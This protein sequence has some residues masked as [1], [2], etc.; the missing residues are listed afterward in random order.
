MAW[1]SSNELGTEGVKMRKR[2]LLFGDLHPFNIQFFAEGGDGEGNNG[3]SDNEGGAAAGEGGNESGNKDDQNKSFD[4]VLKDSNYQAE[5]D[6]RVQK[7]IKTAQEKWDLAMN[8]KLSEAE[9]LAKMTKEQ[10]AEYEE[11]KRI[12]ALEDREAAVTKKELMAEA[13]NTLTDK[14][15]PVG[16]AEL[17]N[18]SDADSCNKSI[19][20]LE[21]AF[22]EAVEA[23][24]A[25]KIKGGSAP[26][27]AQGD[28]NSLES[29]ISNAMKAY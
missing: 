16:L 12:K 7:A 28:D 3:G 17:L 21:K 10:K 20:V 9:K 19:E 23:A 24:V 5:F 2:Q 1:G 13:K 4:D 25:A 14:H 8:D 15:L 26:K 27:K 11:K 29:I 18:Y 22:Q 6:R